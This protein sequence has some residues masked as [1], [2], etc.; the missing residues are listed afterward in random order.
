MRQN[1]RLQDLCA[2]F[3]RAWYV[4]LEPESS[5]FV[6]FAMKLETTNEPL[7]LEVEEAKRFL[8]VIA[9]CGFSSQRCQRSGCTDL[10]LRE[11]ALC[12]AH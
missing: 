2:T 3:N 11:R 1:V 9:H 12:E 6:A 7:F 5:P 8:L 10:A 4:E